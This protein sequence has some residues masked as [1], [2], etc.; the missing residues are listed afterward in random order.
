MAYLIGY[1]GKNKS[2]EKNN[3][4]IN[5]ALEY[6]DKDNLTTV[7]IDNGFIVA[8]YKK[9]NQNHYNHIMPL[10]SDNGIFVGKTFDSNNYDS[11]NF[12]DLNE[13]QIKDLIKNPEK[14]SQSLW[15]RYIGIL[16]DNT[17]QNL[18]LIRD[19]QGLSSIFYIIENNEIFFSTE[20]ALIYKILK[21][22]PEI[23]FDF[24]VQHLIHTNWALES[25]PF[26]NIKELLPGMGLNFNI[27]GTYSSKLLWDINS[28]KGSFVKDKNKI[29][30]ELLEKL[31]ATIKAWFKDSS[32]ICVELSGGTDSSGLML[33]LNDIFKGS[34]KIVPVNYIDSQVQASN[35]IEYAKEIADL[36]N[37]QLN[38]IDW[39]TTSILDKLPQDFRPNRPTTFNLF[40]NL[41]KQTFDLMAKNNCSDLANGQGGDHVFLAPPPESAIADYLLERGLFGITKP[42]K[43]LSGIYRTSWTNLLSKNK[44][45]LFGYYKK[46]RYKNEEDILNLN[47][48]VLQNTKYEKFYLEDIFK[49]IHP[50][51]A[52]HIEALSHAVTYSERDTGSLGWAE[53]HPILFQPIVELGLKIPTYQS[54]ED[55]YD[56]IFFRKAIDRINNSKSMWRRI[57]GHTTGSML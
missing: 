23:N 2:Q 57:K 15:G 10:N 46:N 53:S 45:T 51:K 42:I 25:T 39:Q 55:G 3:S 24:F 33:L 22:K 32:G 44:K 37:T 28:F 9:E 41:R 16:Y 8:G 20:I 30:E 36:C 18:R 1:F 12:S 27:D 7:N 34:K 38:F 31:R 54:F 43:E 14:I 4:L 5:L 56:R 26:K 19:P 13:N 50:G 47:K 29:E 52:Y 35:E 11:V 48:D 40:H 49:K 21:H 6:S 17:T